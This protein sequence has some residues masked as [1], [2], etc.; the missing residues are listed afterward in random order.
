MAVFA[1]LNQ[2]GR[3]VVYMSWTSQRSELSYPAIEKLCQSPKRWCFK[4]THLLKSQH[5]TLIAY[6]RSDAFMLKPRKWQ[7][8]VTY[9]EMVLEDA[10]YTSRSLLRIVMK[11]IPHEFFEV[12]TSIT[13]WKSVACLAVCTRV[14]NS[15]HNK[16]TKSSLIIVQIHIPNSHL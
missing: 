1:T 2:G 16:Y 12:C 6:Q 11:K 7:M 15:S 10:L 14:A 3:A 13:K 9:W 8:P 5:V 4:W